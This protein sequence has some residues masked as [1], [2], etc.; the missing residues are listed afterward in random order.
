MRRVLDGLQKIDEGAE[1]VGQG[2]KEDG[3]EDVIVFDLA[4]GRNT[5]EVASHLRKCVAGGCVIG[6]SNFKRL[7]KQAGLSVGTL[8]VM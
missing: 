1:A 2:M 6:E 7:H 4:Q 8:V 5:A 3:G